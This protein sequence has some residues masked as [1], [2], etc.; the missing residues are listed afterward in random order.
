MS[1]Q[2]SETLPALSGARKAAVLVMGLGNQHSAELIRQ[3]DEHEIRNLSGEIAA[4][5]SVPP[6]E[7]LLVFREFEILSA[8]S[9]LFAK[10]GPEKARKLIEQAIGKESTE[11]MFDERPLPEP[12]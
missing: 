6:E 3:L 7:M 9:K 8:R 12:K 1:P 11:R 4:L 2:S 10:G 5:E